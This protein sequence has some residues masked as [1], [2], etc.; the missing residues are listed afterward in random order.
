[1]DRRCLV[2]GP[3]E[4]LW[5]LGLLLFFALWPE[6]WN[7]R[8]VEFGRLWIHPF[9]SLPATGSTSSSSPGF[10]LRTMMIPPMDTSF[11]GTYWLLSLMEIT[12][13]CCLITLA[14]FWRISELG[15]GSFFFSSFSSFFSFLSSAEEVPAFLDSS[16][17]FFSSFFSSLSVDFLSSLSSS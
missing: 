12:F 7:K 11:I 15:S 8:R 13:S 17:V 1:M 4:W 3:F 16:V 5:W 9:S 2:L 14:G 10:K 6:S